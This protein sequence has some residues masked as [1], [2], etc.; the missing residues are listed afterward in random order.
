MATPAQIEEQVQLERDAIAQG[1]KK[2]KQQTRQLEEKSYASASIYGVASIDTLLPQV[3]KRIEET[4]LRIH[5][6]QNGASF[7]EIAQHLADVEPLAA[8]AIVCKVTFD[9]VFS[10]DDDAS[11]LSGVLN[12]IGQAVE[13]ECQMRHYEAKAPGL[14][15]TIKQ[16]YWHRSCGTQQRLSLIHI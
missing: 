8:A 11:T 7:K 1:L 15:H 3:V 16:N 9:R 6:G 12:C 5:K 10:K 2:L 14:L 13:N 4:T